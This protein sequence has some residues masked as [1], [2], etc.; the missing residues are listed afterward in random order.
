MNGGENKARKTIP[1][2]L[3]GTP[4]LTE[5]L[6]NTLSFTHH[7]K[8]ITIIFSSYISQKEGYMQNVT[9]SHLGLLSPFNE[10]VHFLLS[11]GFS[12]ALEKETRKLML[13]L[14]KTHNS[15]TEYPAFKSVPTPL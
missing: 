4:I 6:W 11:S 9:Q 3:N 5:I 10:K 1:R 13:A 12:S 2:C 8:R 7:D 14:Y 15:Q